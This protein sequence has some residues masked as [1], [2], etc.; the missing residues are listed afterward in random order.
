M[1]EIRAGGLAIRARR[2]GSGGTRQ[3]GE[4]GVGRL[5]Q[6]RAGAPPAEPGPAGST[7]PGSAARS[8]ARR[9]S[10]AVRSSRSSPS[11]RAVA[12]PARLPRGRRPAARTRNSSS[13]SISQCRPLSRI[14]RPRKTRSLALRALRVGGDSRPRVGAIGLRGSS[15]PSGRPRQIQTGSSRRAHAALGPFAERVL[16]QP[17]LARVITDHAQRAAR[18]QR[19]A[20]R[21]Q[22]AASPASSSLTAM[23]T[24]WNSRANSEGPAA[25]PATAGWR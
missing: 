2:S 18:R 14:H 1:K 8:S 6:A 23:R 19:V 15:R 17:V 20:K 22:R 10:R 3:Q 21:R 24:A 7:P 4:L 11:R 13:Q 25:A 16:H 12:K 5:V 9:A